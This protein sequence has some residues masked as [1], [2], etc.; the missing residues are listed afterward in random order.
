MRTSTH[1]ASVVKSIL[2]SQFQGNVATKW[3]NDH[4]KIAINTYMETGTVIIDECG[5]FIDEEY[6]FLAATPD[7]LICSGG[8]IE[9]KCP[10]K[11]SSCTPS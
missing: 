6:P 3:G 7:G 10:Y 4:E 5:L 2:Y 11:A 1:C 9:V 8:I